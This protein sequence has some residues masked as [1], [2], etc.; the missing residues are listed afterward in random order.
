MIGDKRDLW[1]TISHQ[2]GS[3]RVIQVEAMVMMV[4]GMIGKFGALLVTIPDPVIEGLFLVM[5]G[6][7]SPEK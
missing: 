2:V 6:E 3:R 1:S 4:L 5:F 7:S